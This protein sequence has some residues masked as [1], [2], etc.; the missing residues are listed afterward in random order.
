MSIYSDGIIPQ[1]EDDCVV[2]AVGLDNDDATSL[3]PLLSGSNWIL[4]EARTSGEAVELARSG[5]PSVVLCA[6]D[7]SD[8][9]WRLMLSRLQE[10][11]DAPA[12]IVASRFAEEHLWAE[13]LNL[14]G[15][16]VLCLP[17]EGSELLRALFLARASFNR[18]SRGS[19]SGL[20]NLAR[21][22][23]RS[24]V[25]ETLLGFKHSIEDTPGDARSGDSPHCPR[26]SLG[27]M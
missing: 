1:S 16:D 3:G 4:R 19:A 21:A 22:V 5:T 10:L 12:V 27:T 14:G 7:V 9:D 2:F 23:E 15:Y 13:V 25:R 20:E 17:F 11:P 26:A 6:T 18:R 8:G 24:E